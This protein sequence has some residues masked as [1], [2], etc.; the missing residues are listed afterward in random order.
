MAQNLIAEMFKS[1]YADASGVALAAPQIGIQLQVLVV[2]YQDRESKQQKNIALMNPKISYSSEE[3]KEEEEIC[4]SVPNHVGLVLRPDQIK[5]DA[6]DQH[7]KPVTL[8]AN[9]FL[10]RVLQH[11]I[12]HLNGV[13]YIDRVEGEIGA[14]PDFPE[15]RAEPTLRK[16]G[17][18]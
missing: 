4:L 2:S 18:K 9:G 5:V 16:L 12:D 6:F 15:R 14:V 1:L 17:L 7:G 8:E 13:L 3:M 10:A 11:E